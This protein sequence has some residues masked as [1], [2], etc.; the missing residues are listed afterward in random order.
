MST[1]NVFTPLPRHMERLHPG[2]A[3]KV[4]ED[5]INEACQIRFWHKFMA[6]KCN[7]RIRDLERRLE[8]LAD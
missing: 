1:H 3:S 5:R 2:D 6:P 8:S 7:R 4:I